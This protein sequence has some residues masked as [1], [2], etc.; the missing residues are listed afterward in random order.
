MTA[1]NHVVVG[2]LG[3]LVAETLFEA[4]M[5]RPLTRIGL[6]DRF[7]ECG[8]VPHLQ[9]KCRMTVPQIVALAKDGSW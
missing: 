7:I 1:E 3:S 2:G 4:G 9:E 6:P 5:R 8:S